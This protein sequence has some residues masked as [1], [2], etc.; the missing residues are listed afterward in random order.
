L[1]NNKNGNGISRKIPNITVDA[2]SSRRYPPRINVL[3]EAV[4]KQKKEYF[5]LVSKRLYFCLSNGVTLPFQAAL[6]E[7][8]K[9]ETLW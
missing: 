3:E 8:E 2:I 7:F 6:G 4:N 5:Y 9:K 1:E